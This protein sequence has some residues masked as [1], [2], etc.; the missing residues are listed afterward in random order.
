MMKKA[1]GV[2]V[3]VAT[4]VLAGCGHEHSWTAA[5]CTSAAICTS[6]GETSG[7]PLGHDWQ[8]ATCSEAK[9][10]SR[11]LEVD[12][13]P[14][15]HEYADATCTEPKMCKVCGYKDGD[16]LGHDFADATCTE[17]KTCKN[18]G[19]KEGEPL[20]HKC[21]NVTC[22]EDGTCDICGE[23]IPAL[24]HDFVG[25]TCTDAGKCSRCDE[26]E[27]AFGHDFQVVVCG[28]PTKCKKC[29]FEGDLANHSYLNYMCEYC[30]QYEVIILTNGVQISTKP[31]QRR[32]D[33]YQI[34]DAKLK[35]RGSGGT[36]YYDISLKFE[37]TN[38]SGESMEDHFTYGIVKGYDKDGFEVCSSHIE[39]TVNGINSAEI[40]INGSLG[41]VYFEM[42]EKD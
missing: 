2:I 26:K 4:I 14:L 34:V 16:A 27:E 9:K 30:S 42:Q 32:G 19:L 41:A 10:C 28:E 1:M 23:N 25:T 17:T 31:T 8:P 38:N 11:C 18:C 6:C 21:D 29:G 22:T 39:P 12:G 36:K 37:Y 24:G 3:F 35:K 13:E 20:G 40:M 5:T 15:Q 33:E 7:D